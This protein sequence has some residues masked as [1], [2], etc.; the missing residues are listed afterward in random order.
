LREIE[1]ASFVPAK[2][3]PQMA[4][5][6]DVVRHARTLPGLRVMALVPNLRGAEA[7]L[8]AGVHKLTLPV[9]ASAA[10][11]LANVR[12]TREQ[13][14]EELRAIAELRRE[15]APQVK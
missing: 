14:V 8:A 12:R 1:V 9:S 5:A 15:I 3:L 4:D 11:S 2:L 7:A 6:A 13:M 10:H